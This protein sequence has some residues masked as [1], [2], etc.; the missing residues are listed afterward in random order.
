SFLDHEE[1]WLQRAA[2]DAL[3]PIAGQPSTYEK[4]I[5]AVAEL[6]RTNQRP[7]TTVGMHS[8]MRSRIIAA[9]PE[10][11]ELAVKHLGKSYAEF[12]PTSPEPG[13]QDTTRLINNHLRFIA[14][15]LADIPGG[16]DFLYQIARERQP[17]EIL[18]HKD[19]FLQA[20]TAR[21][22]DALRENIKPI[23]RDELIPA[24]VG[25]NREDLENLAKQTAQTQFPGEDKINELAMLH[26]RAG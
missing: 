1:Q 14:E 22:S 4:V 24:Y 26:S 17:N 18:P 20:D 16:Y 25:Q 12:A 11:Q 21:L 7:F 15:S 8:R 3:A 5:P 23:I 10:V 19:I 6:I 9:A 13:G 2:L